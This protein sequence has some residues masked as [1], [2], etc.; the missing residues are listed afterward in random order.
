MHHICEV[1]D[2]P[3]VHD[4]YPHVGM[5]ADWSKGCTPPSKPRRFKSLAAPV[6]VQGVCTRV[7][8]PAPSIS[9]RSLPTL[10]RGHSL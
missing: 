1:L 3:S 9:A 7:K 8:S 6:T 2:W 5:A 10:A 4:L